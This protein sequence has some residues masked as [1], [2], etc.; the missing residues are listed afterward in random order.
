MGGFCGVRGTAN[1]AQVV[2][3]LDAGKIFGEEFGL[4]LGSVH[5]CR[6]YEAATHTLVDGVMINVNIFGAARRSVGRN[7]G[8]GSAVVHVNLCGLEDPSVSLDSASPT[9]FFLSNKPG[10]CLK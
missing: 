3:E 5:S 9:P 1:E 10:V 6:T 8:D 2:L 7:H 4:F